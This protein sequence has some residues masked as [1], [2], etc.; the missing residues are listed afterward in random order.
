MGIGFLGRLEMGGGGD[1][2]GAQKLGEKGRM[3]RG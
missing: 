2:C 1:D 3:M